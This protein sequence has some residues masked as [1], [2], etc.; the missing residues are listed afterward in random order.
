MRIFFEMVNEEAHPCEMRC[1]WMLP[2]DIV[3]PSPR[4]VSVFG[5]T[6]AAAG[7]YHGGER[8]RAVRTAGGCTPFH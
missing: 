6:R 5:L 1:V 2:A 7:E 3:G 4:S 8:V